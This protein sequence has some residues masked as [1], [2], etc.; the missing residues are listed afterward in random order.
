MPFAAFCARPSHDLAAQAVLRAGRPEAAIAARGAVVVVALVAAGAVF[1]VVR[2]GGEKAATTTAR[3]PGDDANLFYLRGIA[4][5]T[6]V[7]GCAMYIHFTWK[8]DYHADQYIGAP[9]L[10]LVAGP[11]IAGHVQA[12]P[13]SPPA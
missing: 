4:P 5:T 7:Q 10:I 13:S 11:G 1:A 3:A 12:R 9:A 6:K 8:P 2:G